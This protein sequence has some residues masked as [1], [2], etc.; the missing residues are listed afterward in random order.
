MAGFISE[1]DPWTAMTL[2]FQPPSRGIAMRFQSLA[3][4]LSSF[5]SG[6][7]VQ[8]A[9][10][11]LGVKEP[12]RR[13]HSQAKCGKFALKILIIT[14]GLLLPAAL[15]GGWSM[16]EACSSYRG[17]FRPADVVCDVPFHHELRIT[18]ARPPLRAAPAGATGQA[19]KRSICRTSSD[20]SWQLACDLPANQEL[21]VTLSPTRLPRV[22]CKLFIDCPAQY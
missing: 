18:V 3:A 11:A 9:S 10:V 22:K 2:R 19:A 5:L 15:Y 4:W 1:L 8:A 17:T 21:I 13:I 6:T 12:R 14:I 20:I 16:N 7:R